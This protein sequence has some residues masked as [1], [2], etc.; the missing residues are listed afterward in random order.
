VVVGLSVIFG[1][2]AAAWAQANAN[3]DNLYNLSQNQYGTFGS[4]TLGQGTN[5]SS[6]LGQSNLNTMG[7]SLS[8][9]NTGMGGAVDINQVNT[10]GQLI[11]NNARPA[12]FVGADSQDLGNFMSLMQSGGYGSSGSG[13]G[14]GGYGSGS[15]RY[16]TSNRN[17]GLNT[18]GGYNSLYGGA[19]RY[20]ANQYGA[21]N[22]NSRYGMGGYYGGYG[23]RGLQDVRASV[24]VGFDRPNAATPNLS[25]TL[26]ARL[27]KSA[28]LQRLSPVQVSLEQG[29]AILRGTVATD[30][31]RDLAEQ[32]VRLEPGVTA[33]RNELK[34]GTA[35]GTPPTRQALPTPPSP[36]GAAGR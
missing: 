2:P 33:V 24:Q 11:G 23:S 18:L 27:E 32:V 26:T 25:Q 28:R 36:P 1:F 21:A 35:A 4:R 30:H 29:T 20:G 19:N 14:S 16:G 10:A 12:G 13:L 6:S 15:N 8:G 9:N 7:S 31:D 3:L 17:S 5:L 22:R 34:V